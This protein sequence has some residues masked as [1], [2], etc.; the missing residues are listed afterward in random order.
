MVTGRRR[1]VDDAS[2]D[3]MT[4]IVRETHPMAWAEES[5][6]SYHWRVEAEGEEPRIVAEAW[7]HQTKRGWWL[8]IEKM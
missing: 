3:T 7:M 2:S 6:G 8:R 4:S 1:Y 5:M